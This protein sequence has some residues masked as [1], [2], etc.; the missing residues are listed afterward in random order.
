MDVFNNGFWKK[1]LN[2]L[3]PGLSPLEQA[4]VVVIIRDLKIPR[5]RRQRKHRLKSVHLI[6]IGQSQLAYFVK[7]G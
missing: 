6:F 5:R 7:C 3:V 2:D 1:T 4:V